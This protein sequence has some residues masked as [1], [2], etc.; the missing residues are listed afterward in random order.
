MEKTGSQTYDLIIIGGGSAGMAAAIYAARYRLNT[1]M[2]SK[3]T[4]GLANEAH[5]VENYPGYTSISG[6]E[7]MGK[8]RE[9]VESLGVKIADEEAKDIHKDG[10]EF[11]IA[12]DENLYISKTI[13]V[14]LGTERRKLNL[15]EEKKYVGRGVSYCATCDAAFFKGKDVA[16]V[17]GSDAAGTAALLLAQYARKVYIIYR[18]SPLRAEPITIAKIDEDKRIE[19]VLACN[20]AAI[21]GD[22]KVESVL[23]DTGKE[24]KVDG[25]FVE[26]GGVPAVSLM[27]RFDLKTDEAG[28]IVVDKDMVTSIPGVYA[29]GDITNGSNLKQIITAAAQGATAAYSAFKYLKKGAVHET[30]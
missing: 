9:Q 28:Q 5:L 12:T 30:H 8:F 19:Q 22:K 17:G 15:P 18:K 20:I 10:K 23:L 7:L 2:I 1:L 4:G 3:E 21:K 6:I 25:I 11:K 13:I 16:V 29:A 14:A 24:I 27:H 26:I